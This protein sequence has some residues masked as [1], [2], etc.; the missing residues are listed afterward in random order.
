MRNAFMF[1][2]EGV[3]AIFQDGTLVIK[4]AESNLADFI[5]AEDMEIRANCSHLHKKS[6]PLTESLDVISIIGKLL[7]HR[8]LHTFRSLALLKLFFRLERVPFWHAVRRT[9]GLAET[10]SRPWTCRSSCCWWSPRNH[11]LR[12]SLRNRTAVCGRRTYPFK[13]HGQSSSRSREDHRAV[14]WR[15]SFS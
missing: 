8:L 14:H 7:Q 13:H 6:R 9:R 10:L 15:H 2:R 3:L 11:S 5:A 4:A 1:K 12:G